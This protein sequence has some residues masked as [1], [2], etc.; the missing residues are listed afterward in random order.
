MP[1]KSEVSISHKP[2]GLLK[3]SPTGLSELNVLGSH[4]P[5]AGPP[6]CGALYGNYIPC[7]MGRTFAILIILPFVDLLLRGVGLGFTITPLLLHISVLF[8]LYLLN[9]RRSF[10]VGSNL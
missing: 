5:R 1:F 9:C 7:S 6:G 3:L 10:L 2:L 4:L 8:L